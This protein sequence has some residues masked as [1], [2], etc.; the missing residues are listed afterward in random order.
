MVL[1]DRPIREAIAAGRIVVDPFDDAL[2]QPSSV[3]L[4]VGSSSASSATPAIR[5]STCSSRWRTSP[6]WSTRRGRA[7][8][9]ASGRVRAGRHAERVALGDDLVARSTAKARWAG[10]DCS[11]HST[12]GLSTPASTATSRSSSPN[13]ANLPIT[14]Y[15]GMKIGQLSFLQHDHAGRPPLRLGLTRQQVPGPG[16]ADPEPLPPELPGPAVKV[17]VT[18]A[19][20]LRRPRGGRGRSPRPATR[21][22]LVRPGSGSR[23]PPA[24]RR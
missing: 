3:D 18:G 7:V 1:S 19:H 22:G 11:I 17:L 15:P 23:A 12:A 5:T 24:S 8:R 6:S 10:W 14:I 21:R 4:R 9:A 13:M 16:R 2:V 20:R